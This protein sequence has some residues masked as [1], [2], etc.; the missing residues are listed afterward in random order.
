MPPSPTGV[1][2]QLGPKEF[3][4]AVLK[5]EQAAAYMQVSTTWLEESAVPVVGLPTTGTSNRKL[6]RYRRTDLDRYIEDHLCD[7]RITL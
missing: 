6:R 1:L 3:W 5:F 4:P 2:A 7:Q